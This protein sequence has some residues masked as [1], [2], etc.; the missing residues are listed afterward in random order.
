VTEEPKRTLNYT[1]VLNHIDI[2]SCLSP[3]YK[4]VPELS[5]GL[6]TK[7]KADVLK[8]ENNNIPNT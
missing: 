1:T 3:S 2:N 5:V 7:P 8:K 4:K 6:F